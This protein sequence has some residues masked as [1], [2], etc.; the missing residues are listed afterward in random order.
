MI[1]YQILSLQSECEYW[2]NLDIC[3]LL[4]RLHTDPSCHSPGPSLPPPPDKPWNNRKYFRLR[5]VCISDEVFSWLCSKNACKKFSF[6]SLKSLRED[7]K[8]WFWAIKMNKKL[9]ETDGRCDRW[10]LLGPWLS[11]H[12]GPPAI[13]LT[14][15]LVLHAPRAKHVVSDVVL[16]QRL[17]APR[18]RDHGHLDLLQHLRQE[19]GALPSHPPARHRH[20]IVQPHSW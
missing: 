12:E 11:A 10:Y 8:I 9:F 2:S 18:H 3:S 15:V 14:G 20:W 6:Q 5:I 16:A 13:P 17:L 4:C 7:E 19:G 1:N